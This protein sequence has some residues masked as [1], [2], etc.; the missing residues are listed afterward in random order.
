M[1]CLVFQ[2]GDDVLRHPLP[3]NEARIGSDP[4][5][6]LVVP[7]VGVSRFHA[8]YVPDGPAPRLYDLGSKNGLVAGGKRV[9]E[10]VLLPGLR[11]Q[12]GSAVIWVEDGETADVDLYLEPAVPWGVAPDEK[13][14]DRSA[15]ETVGPLTDDGQALGFLR[16]LHRSIGAPLSEA[17]LGALLGRLGEVVG[18]QGA[19]LL[20][21]F[22]DELVTIAAAGP[23]L[24]PAL[25]RGLAGRSPSPGAV[26]DLTIAGR[27]VAVLE[28]AE[29]DGM[30][31]VVAF[32]PGFSRAGWRSDLVDMA[33]ESLVYGRPFA[34]AERSSPSRAPSRL[35]VP[36]EMVWGESRAMNDLRRRLEKIAPSRSDVLVLGET[37]TGKEL[38][39][40]LIHASGPTAN[41]PFVALNCAAIPAELLEAE[42][43]GVRAR[44]ATGV[45]ARPGRIREADG[46]TLV[47]DEIGELPPSLQAKLLRFL[48]ERE[49]QAVGGTGAERVNVRVVSVSNRDLADEVRDGRFRADLFHRVRGLECRVPPLRDCR[50]DI[51]ALVGAFAAGAATEESKR[52][53]GISRKAMAALMAHDWPGNVRELKVEVRRAVV[54]CP[55]GGSLASEHFAE[56]RCLASPEGRI[57]AASG[58]SVPPPARTGQPEERER[59]V[60]TDLDL[61]RGV[62]RL[63]A[64]LIRAA[65]ERSSGNRTQAASLLGL[66]RAGL[67]MKLKR[68][69]GQE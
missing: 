45:D 37:G 62:D 36:P 34:T 58:P 68:L 24:E 63:E 41:G 46:G 26:R 35:V 6:E 31:A 64:S 57:L 20:R 11:V 18:A 54:L 33:L 12:A 2:I 17:R 9:R 66:T 8:R 59:V 39:A 3:E 27:A 29:G 69:F 32:P 19:A 25:L 67:R 14:A 30:M 65:L 61:K 42:L 48:Q 15:T 52:V 53:R 44:A 21:R 5:N 22:G 40:R 1:R 38:V 55:D 10:V 47:L 7:A 4:A 49:V 60:E 56:M 51:P 28:S 23:E 16:E 50:E 43:F 13:K